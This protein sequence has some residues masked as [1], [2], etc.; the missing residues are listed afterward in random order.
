MEGDCEAMKKSISK[1][2]ALQELTVF[3]LVFMVLLGV[4]IPNNVVR[5]DSE[6][7]DPPMTGLE[8]TDEEGNISTEGNDGSQAEDENSEG[9]DGSQAEDENSEENDGGQAEEE[10]GEEEAEQTDEEMQPFPEMIPMKFV[11]G[12]SME[13]GKIEVSDDNGNIVDESTVKEHR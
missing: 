2:I 3:F 6:Q 11:T 12:T 9:N 4:M 13:N 1:R 5:A 8:I 10:N 7:S